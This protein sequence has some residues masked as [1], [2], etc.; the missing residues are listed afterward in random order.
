VVGVAAGEVEVVQHEDDRPAGP[1]VEVGEEGGRHRLVVG[2][3]P[4]PEPALVG[5]AAA[6]N[7][8]ADVDPGRIPNSISA[9][10]E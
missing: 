1:A 10:A 9:A 4:L 3:A 7:Q 6:A 5:V 2:W 8:V